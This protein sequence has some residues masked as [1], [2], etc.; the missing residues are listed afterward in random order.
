[1]TMPRQVLPG[2][3]YL[4]TRRTRSRRFFLLPNDPLVDIIFKFCVAYAAKLTG[5]KVHA[6][7]VMSNH[8]HLV[9]T[10][11][12]GRLPEFTHWLFRHSAL[13]LK[14]LRG[15][16]ENVWAAERKPP[17]ALLTEQA[18]LDAMAYVMVNPV[19][20][21]LV[22][23]FYQWPGWVSRPRD[24]VSAAETVSAPRQYF[25]GQKTAR[26]RLHV[27]EML[28]ASYEAGE[29]VEMLEG[30]VEEYEERARE[31][32]VASRRPVVGAA[33]VRA[34]S[35]FA[36]PRTASRGGASDDEGDGLVPRFKALCRR[37]L[38]EARRRLRWFW[39]AYREALEN[40]QL[41]RE[42]VFPAGTWWYREHLGVAVTE[43][44]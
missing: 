25:K 11:I 8:V 28:E 4:L 3:T 31:A 16:D 13:C 15:I 21:G 14:A 12:K 36:Q 32:R 27:P 20:A 37:E 40:L 42:A 10:D 2:T 35:P 39:Q 41:G 18:V 33:R 34:M 7:C 9:L 29:V 26:L 30:L 17:V 6:V 23:H 38:K 19:K 5:V 43:A 1:M 22:S 44:Y 24:L